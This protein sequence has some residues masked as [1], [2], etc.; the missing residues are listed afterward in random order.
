MDKLTNQ[1]YLEAYEALDAKRHEIYQQQQEL[2]DG[3]G[4]ELP[5]Y[6]PD[7]RIILPAGHSWG[8]YEA[9]VLSCRP[10]HWTKVD[11][12]QWSWRIDVNVVGYRN[13]AFFEPIALDGEHKHTAKPAPVDPAEEP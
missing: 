13:S 11:R 8:G 3:W 5:P 6:Q 10:T 1:L 2:L 12:L 4:R 9:V 7:E